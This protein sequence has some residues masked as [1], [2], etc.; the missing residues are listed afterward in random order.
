M[1][2]YTIIVIIEVETQFFVLRT[3]FD[4]DAGGT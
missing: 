2:E 4:M 3:T 1:L